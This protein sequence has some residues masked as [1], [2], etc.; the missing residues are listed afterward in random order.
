MFAIAGGKGGSG[1]TT[2]AVGVARALARQGRD[3]ILVDCDTDMPD[4]HHLLGIEAPGGIDD[5]ASGTA[6]ERAWQFSTAAPGVR[7]LTAGDRSNVDTALARLADWHDPV[8]LDCPPGVG[9]DAVRPLRHASRAVVVSTDQPASLADADTTARTARELGT[10]VVG[11][12]L[13][14]TDSPAEPAPH[15]DR[16]VLVTVRSVDSP[17]EDPQIRQAWTRVAGHLTSGPPRRGRSR[18]GGI[19]SDP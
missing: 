12:V 10:D 15:A 4:L 6:L 17:L 3:P 11:T 5:L 9:P 19:S 16:R 1:K 14:E 2:T 7:C 8:I 18:R 13:R